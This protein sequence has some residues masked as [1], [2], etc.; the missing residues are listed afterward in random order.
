MKTRAELEAELIARVSDDEAFRARLLENPREVIQEAIGIAI[1]ED[2]AIQVHEE[3]SMTAHV[4]LPAGDRLTQ[5][6]LAAVAG[7]FG[8]MWG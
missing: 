4:V 7:G 8:A 5:D 1:P 3:N 2:F 6:D